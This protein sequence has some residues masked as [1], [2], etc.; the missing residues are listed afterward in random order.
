MVAGGKRE[1]AGRPRKS[2]GRV[3]VRLPEWIM[4]ELDKE[5][6]KSRAIV[7]CLTL[8]YSKDI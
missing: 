7:R 5:E 1:G 6:D 2:S 4:R 8:Y 3:T